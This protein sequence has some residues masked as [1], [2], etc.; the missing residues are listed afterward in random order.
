MSFLTGLSITAIIAAIAAFFNQ[1]KQF[2]RHVSGLVLFQKKVIGGL[3]TPVGMYIRN[4]MHKLPSGIS[5]FQS[6]YGNIGDS[7]RN[8]YIPFEMPA[9][10]GLWRCEHG[11][12]LISVNPSTINIVSLRWLSKPQELI[13]SA[14]RFQEGLT[15]QA[16]EGMGNY[17]VTQIMGSAGDMMADYRDGN[18]RRGQRN[19]TIESDASS[20]PPIGVD[21]DQAWGG[22]DTR[23]DKSF[24]YEQSQYIKNRQGK[25]P[26]RGLFFDQPVHDLINEMK[27]W[28]KQREWYEERGIPWR[29]G[30]L[31]HGPGGTGKSSLAKVV[32]QTLGIPLQQFY[33]N[34]LT[35]REFMDNWDRMPTPCVVALEDFDTVFHGREPV[36]VHKSLSFECVLNKISGISSVNGVCLMV[37]T[38]HIEHIDPALGQIDENGRPTRPGRIDRILELRYSSPKVQRDLAEYVLGGWASDLVETAIA[39]GGDGITAAQF[40]SLCIQMALERKNDELNASL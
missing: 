9:T 4:E 27:R 8:S 35:D 3:C 6:I 21:S 39:Q 13:K 37:N 1:V 16:E 28:F 12:F 18:P 15:A 23:V 29:F 11:T 38:N 32:A 26:M 5:T 14:L 34:T 40:Q 31:L 30:V 17:Y 22:I 24:M 7:S 36:T 19:A 33:L 25:D 2:F 10:T 20:A